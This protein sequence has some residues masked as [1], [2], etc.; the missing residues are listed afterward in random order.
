MAAIL[1]V[2][3]NLIVLSPRE[4]SGCF[5]EVPRRQVGVAHSRPDV[6]VSHEFGYGSDIDSLHGEVRAVGVSQVVDPDTWQPG[7]L[8]SLFERPSDIVALAGLAIA[9]KDVTSVSSGFTHRVV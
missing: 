2:I 8:Q 9:G 6:F 5:L 1:V 4:F 7:F 3:F